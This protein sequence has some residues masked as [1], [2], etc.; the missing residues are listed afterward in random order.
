MSHVI[1]CIDGSST[2]PAVCD[3]AGWASQLLAAPVTLL[4]VLE[5]P[6][7]QGV[8]DLSGAIGLG[9]RELLMQQ[10]AELDEQRSR[11]AREQGQLLLEAARARVV[12]LG[13]LEVQLRQRHGLLVDCLQELEAQIRLLV[14]GRHG[15][16]GD[17]LGRR[18]GSQLENVVRTLHCHILVT[19]ERFTPPTQ[20]MIAFD[21]SASAQRAVAKVAATPLLAGLPVH[22]VTVG[23]DNPETRRSQLAALE[24]LE[25]AGLAVT[26]MILSGEVEGA[27]RRYQAEQGIDL[28]VMGAWGHSRMRQW[29]VGSTTTA[30]VQHADVPLLLVR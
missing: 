30:M 10:L 5:Q 18:I 4:H 7:A 16:Q 12:E 21:G 29:L 1:A 17:S 3:C 2:S 13:A 11:A 6:H 15:Q 24:V 14:M 20:V 28:L 25:Q 19:T 9:S 26:S 23:S 22:L 8:T 27:L